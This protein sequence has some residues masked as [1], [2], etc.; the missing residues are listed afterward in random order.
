MK[1]NNILATNPEMSKPKK[2]ELNG[3]TYKIVGGNKRN[4]REVI[5]TR[6]KL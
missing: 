1:E 4:G 3:S 6:E 5:I 2:L